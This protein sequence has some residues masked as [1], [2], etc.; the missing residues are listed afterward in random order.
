MTDSSI[1]LHDVL[2]A[3]P[4]ATPWI[5]RFGTDPDSW[6]IDDAGLPGLGLMAQAVIQFC[7]I[8]EGEG[9]SIDEIACAF[10]MPIE[11]VDLA[12][13]AGARLM[14]PPGHELVLS[15]ICDLAMTLVATRGTEDLSVEAL[16]LLTKQHPTVIIEAVGAHPYAYL[17]GDRDDLAKLFVGLDGE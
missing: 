3:L 16:G 13:D 17:T 14:P 2:A 12:R 4:P 8:W 1:T 10:N 15:E 5:D 9:A 6:N 7:F 11:L